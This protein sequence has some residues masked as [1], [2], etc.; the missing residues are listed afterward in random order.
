MLYDAHNALISINER[1]AFTFNS[2]FA[3]FVNHH[4][5]GTCEFLGGAPLSP[6]EPSASS[7]G[8]LY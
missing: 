1:F 2:E 3:S 8:M 5:H 4:L 7:N 6:C